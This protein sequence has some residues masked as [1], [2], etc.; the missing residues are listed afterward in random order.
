[1]NIFVML[2]YKEKSNFVSKMLLEGTSNA[3]Y[4]HENWSIPL[5]LI[6]FLYDGDF[7]HGVRTAGRHPFQ[8]VEVFVFTTFFVAKPPITK[9]VILWSTGTQIR[10][11]DA[12]ILQLVALVLIYLLVNYLA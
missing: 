8:R 6:G 1:M 5:E 9:K 10:K 12:I 7:G 4:E 3:R 2:H 11:N